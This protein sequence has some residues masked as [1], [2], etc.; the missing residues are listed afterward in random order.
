MQKM[1]DSEKAALRLEVEKLRRGEV[2]WLQVLVRILDHVFVLH[3]AA[4][5]S[6][7]PKLAEQITNFKMPAATPRA[8]SAWCRL[9]PSRM[10]R[11]TPNATRSAGSKE[12][13]PAGAVVAETVGAGSRFRA[14]FCAPRSCACATGMRPETSRKNPNPLRHPCRKKPEDQLPLESPE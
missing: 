5:R 10:S 4:M 8:A 12:K 6:G 9:P 2:E 14:G 11:S 3:A 13:P 1:N 7:Q